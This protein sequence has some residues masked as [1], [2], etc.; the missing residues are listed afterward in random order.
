MNRNLNRILGLVIINKEERESVIVAFELE[1]KN[2]TCLLFTP[3]TN[4]KI[5]ILTDS[6]Q[7]V[8]NMDITSVTWNDAIHWFKYP[9][10]NY[11]RVNPYEKTKNPKEYA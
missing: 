2:W 11:E 10:E 9:L 3:K 1:N 7:D 5:N 4:K 6:I 8:D